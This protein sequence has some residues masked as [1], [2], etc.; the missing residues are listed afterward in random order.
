MGRKAPKLKQHPDAAPI[1]LRSYT[2]VLE[3]E[4]ERAGE[5]L[6]AFLAEREAEDARRSR[7]QPWPPGR[8]G[9]SASRSDFV[10]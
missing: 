7:G 9:P 8:A 5:Q 10:P 1:T 2:H 3:G 6:D 4:L